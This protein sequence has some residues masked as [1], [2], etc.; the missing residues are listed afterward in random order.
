[1]QEIAN[2][3]FN[4]SSLSEIMPMIY[5][6]FTEKSAE[7]WRQIYKALQLLEFLIKNGSERVIDDARSH[8]SLLKMLR[9]F[10][11]IDSN[12]KDQG[13]NVRNR[14]KELTELLS[15]VD[16]IRSERKKAR[17]TRNKYGGSEGGM[18]LGGMSSG[19]RYGGFGSETG[20]G[21]NGGYGGYSGGVFGDGGGFGGQESS[22]AYGTTQ[23]RRDR[24]QEYDEYDEG[25]P[26]SPAPRRN[27]PNRTTPAAAPKTEPPK[28]KAPEVDLFEFGDEEV[29]SAPTAPHV[30]NGKASA[31]SISALDDFGTMQSGA[32][33]DEFDDFQQAGPSALTNILSPSQSTVNNT[34]IPPPAV[35]NSA[36]APAPIPVMSPPLP[37][38][39]AR[40][41][42][43]ANYSAFRAPQP[44]TNTSTPLQSPPLQPSNQPKATGYQPQG[45]NYFGSISVM[46]TSNSGAS[47]PSAS[48]SANT[49]GIGGAAKPLGTQAAKKPASGADPFASLAMG[50]GKKTTAQKGPT[51]AEMSKQKANQGL[52]GATSQQG[53]SGGSNGDLI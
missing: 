5:K 50:G 3:T 37:T 22:D 25:G 39:A 17:S 21:L 10:H 6:R 48:A 49:S 13:I 47:T 7:E 46:Q 20:G 33:D 1:M 44:S 34:A 42:S 4:Y 41:S 43:T 9:Q 8:M 11:Y 16:R 28:P 51:M 53:A 12:G 27:P 40:P 36:P 30:T 38:G 31:S 29:S 32:G 24:F 23:G 18:G 35:P 14:S 15:D 45:P 2:G 26:T 19:G 52:W